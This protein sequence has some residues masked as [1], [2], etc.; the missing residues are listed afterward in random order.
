MALGIARCLYGPLYRSTDGDNLVSCVLGIIDQLAV[1]FRDIHLLGVHLM[2]RKV[3]YIGS[4]KVAK[5]TMK[6]DKCAVNAIYFHTLE[7]LSRE[8]ETC[9]RCG[10]SSFVLGKEAL[11]TIEVLRL[12]RTLLA[13]DIGQGRLAKCIKL[14]LKLVM[15][16]IVEKS[17]RAAAASRI[18]YD[19]S[20][21]AFVLTK[22]ELVAD[23]NLAGRIYQDIPQT[24]VGIKLTAQEHLDT[25]T[26][27]LLVA[28]KTSRDDLGI[29]EDE[30]VLFLE[31]AQKI[32]EHLVL[33][34]AC[35]PVKY[36][37]A[38]LIPVGGGHKGDAVFRQLELKL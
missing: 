29:I 36:H 38:A 6:R 14:L 3:L 10:H 24:Q 25:R 16:T 18:V 11:E 13:D 20:N 33:N 35:L 15:R 4:I 27:L 23:T 37:H 2:L 5:A 21:Y 8:V 9:C 22:V 12:D 32:L 30:D 31:I 17:Q 1:F 7:H 34:L 26:G 19:L 28:V